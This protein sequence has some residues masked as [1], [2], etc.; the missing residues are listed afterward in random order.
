ME[1]RENENYDIILEMRELA[2]KGMAEKVVEEIN[3]LDPDFFN[4]NPILLF[5]LKQVAHL[6]LQ[7]YFYLFTLYCCAFLA[8]CATPGFGFLFSFDLDK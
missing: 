1:I 3:C 2:Y 8:G 4:Q 7:S 6:F 5:Q